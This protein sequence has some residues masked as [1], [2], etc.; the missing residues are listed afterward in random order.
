MALSGDVR[1]AASVIM[2]TRALKCIFLYIHILLVLF[3]GRTLTLMQNAFFLI[4][5]RD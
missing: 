3:L 4:Q 2:G 1:P 5:V